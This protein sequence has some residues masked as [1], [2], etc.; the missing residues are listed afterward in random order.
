MHGREICGL[1]SIAQGP[2]PRLRSAGTSR[3][4]DQV[5][6]PVNVCGNESEEQEAK[7]RSYDSTKDFHGMA[8]CLVGLTQQVLDIVLCASPGPGGS[9]GTGYRAGWGRCKL[10]WRSECR[11]GLR[12]CGQAKSY[13]SATCCTPAAATAPV[14]RRV[15]RIG[16]LAPWARA[17]SA[18]RGEPFVPVHG[19]LRATDPSAPDPHRPWLHN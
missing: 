14:V 13:P 5:G 12:C 16:V 2:C 4:V 15:G 10:R 3:R 17:A 1:L 8:R 11:F 7:Y 9:E 18:R 19:F 6:A